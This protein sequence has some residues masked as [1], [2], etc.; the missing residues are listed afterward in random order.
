MNKDQLQHCENMGRS[1]AVSTFPHRT[2]WHTHATPQTLNKSL[3]NGCQ[4]RQ[5]QITRAPS[6]LTRPSTDVG[7][8]SSMNLVRISR[9]SDT[10][11]VC[12][13]PDFKSS[14]CRLAWPTQ[15]T[16]CETE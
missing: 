10:N 4:Q 8:R 15:D 6:P 11:P 5:E 2:P 7:N 16:L 3:I 9:H 12:W 1:N 14:L 13:P